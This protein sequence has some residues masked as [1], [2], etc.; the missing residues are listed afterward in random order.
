MSTAAPGTEVQRA[1]PML[2]KFMTDL[3]ITSRSIVSD[4]NGRLYLLNPVDGTARLVKFDPQ[5]PVAGANLSQTTRS[6][7]AHTNSTSADYGKAGQL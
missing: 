4:V 7:G 6:D 5:G 3:V 2:P 1:T